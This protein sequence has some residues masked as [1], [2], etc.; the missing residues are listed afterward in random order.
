MDSAR[1]LLID[2]DDACGRGGRAEHKLRDGLLKARACV[3]PGQGPVVGLLIVGKGH[4]VVGKGHGLARGLG[5]IVEAQVEGRLT[6]LV[7]VEG[8]AHEQVLGARVGV[9]LRQVQHQL[10]DDVGIPRRLSELGVKQEDIPFL[11]QSAMADACTP[12]NPRDV[13]QAAIE[14]IY[15][16][17]Y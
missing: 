14:E 17:I 7:A 15:R 8:D 1:G 12:G 16:S 13:T 6:C 11:A 2:R 9:G 4:V 10:A 5:H 3:E